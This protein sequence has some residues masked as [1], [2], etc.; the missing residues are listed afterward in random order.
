MD[1]FC[2]YRP[3]KAQRKKKRKTLEECSQANEFVSLH[4]INEWNISFLYFDGI[5]INGDKKRYVQSVPFQTLSI[6][7]YQEPERSTIGQ[8]IWIQSIEGHKADIWYRLRTPA[9]EYHR[10]HEPFLW[11]ADLA[12]HIIDY[13]SIQLQ[14]TLSSFREDFYSWLQGLYDDNTKFRKWL[15]HANK[16]FRNI[17]TAHANFLYCQASQFDPS[18]G[19]HHLW[20]EIHSQLL[21]AIEEQIEQVCNPQMFAPFIRGAIT[22]LVR[23]TT[24]TPYVFDCFKH[25]GWA[26]F[27][28]CQIP[29]RRLKGSVNG[30]IPTFHNSSR[31]DT[32]PS[33]EHVANKVIFSS[34]SDSKDIDVGDVVALPRDTV[35]AWRTNDVVW[36]GYVQGIRTT[37]EERVLELLW[38]YR[39]S[40]T[41]CRRMYYPYAKELFLSDHCNCGDAPILI[42]DV[43]HKPRVAFFG[44]PSTKDVDFFVRQKY[45]QGDGAW[46]SL[47]H[48]DFRC[49]C[50]KRKETAKY[51]IGD[52][53]LVAIGKRLEPVVLV[54]ENPEDSSGIIFVR[55]L[56]RRTDYG[57]INAEPNELV[58]TNQFQYLDRAD[59]HRKCH[60]RFYTDSDKA[61]GNIP[62]PYCRHGTAD[63]FYIIL[64]DLDH[65]ESVLRPFS[66]A[67]LDLINQ[68]WNP[69]ITPSQSPMRGLDLF[70][71]GG[72]FGRGLE[73]G[74][75]VRVRWVVEWNK[76]AIH[77]YKANMVD[78]DA[79][80]FFFGSV[81]H[82]LSQAMRG[83]GRGSIAQ[84]GDPDIIIAG[85]PCPGYSRANHQK[86]NDKG[87]LDCSMIAS[88]VSFVDFYRPKYAV[89][90]NVYGLASGQDTNNVLAQ[91]MCASV[92][93]GYQTRTF[94]LDSWSSGS[95][96][97]RSRVGIT[98]AAPGLEPMLEPFP[99]HSHPE[100]VRGASLGKMANGLHT[101][102]RCTTLTPFDY[103]SA[104]QA[105]KDLPETDGRT[106][107]IRFPDHRMS[108]A[109]STLHRNCISNIPRFPGGGSFMSAFSRGL[110]PQAQIDDFSWDNPLMARTDTRS[111]S[112]IRRNG[113]IPTVMTR[114][115]P[116]D[117]IGPSC[118]HWDQHRVLTV[119]EV[120]R[121]QTF[122]DHEVLVGSPNAQWKIIG[123]SVD[124]S[125]ALSLGM[126]LRTAWLANSAREA[127]DRRTET[128]IPKASGQL[129]STDLTEASSINTLIGGAVSDL[130]HLLAR[131]NSQRLQ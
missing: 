27:L 84:F 1:N 115:Q 22:S 118:L 63:H 85:S 20:K 58:F 114:P 74:G 101:S 3:H 42:K 88:V 103:V 2:I 38:L 92:G 36:Y 77:T 95:S 24:V 96:Q 54:K 93:M 78:Q 104:A 105:T 49:D 107:C 17:V 57:H 48:S 129:S 15:S 120:R 128:A 126:S 108:F 127:V 35:S 62:P 37:K 68:G 59:I 112:R 40:D 119:M 18:L 131:R 76:E 32:S 130:W 80:H 45:A 10:F 81:N 50:H 34:E 41:E 102:S 11:I 94:G 61:Q 52:T 29:T 113:L 46:I 71:G 47:K 75:A 28:F 4:E 82:Y 89:I 43:T 83:E 44:T 19:D 121:A 30:G 111:W 86:A 25:L 70:S 125:V 124:R 109:L 12:K 122:P 72:N 97:S 106:S 65:N 55:R 123:N 26:K 73:E 91:I 79:T 60:V 31:K 53:L 9:P 16:D 14:A 69:L 6:G 87:L 7:G 23:K 100:N 5:I 33:K 98:I 13:I 56:L 51:S 67:S 8:D 116:W 90:E 110:M 99:T 64:E 39:P 66:P 117:G 21:N